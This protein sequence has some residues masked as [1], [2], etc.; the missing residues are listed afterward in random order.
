MRA[1]HKNVQRFLC[2]V[3]AIFF[4]FSMAACEASYSAEQLAAAKD[5][6]YDDGYSEGYS[7]AESDHGDDYGDGYDEGYSEGYADAEAEFKPQLIDRYGEGYADGYADGCEDAGDSGDTYEDY[8]ASSYTYEEP[9]QQTYS[10]T[11]YVTNT[12]SKYHRAGCQYLRDSQIAIDLDD[13]IAAG[14]TACSRC[15]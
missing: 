8:T 11:V 2:A 10:E 14:Y 7:D 13:A 5:E 4:V 3:F 6:G 12:G 9:V 15:Y 1:S